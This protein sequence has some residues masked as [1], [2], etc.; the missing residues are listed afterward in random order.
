M[1]VYKN[2]SNKFKNNN[3]PK[4]EKIASADV[5]NKKTFKNSIVNAFIK[6]DKETIIDY[7]IKDVM[8]PM[9]KDALDTAISGAIH[10]LLYGENVSVF[11]NHNHYN[12]NSVNSRAANK[13]AYT[14]TYK[15]TQDFSDIVLK[16]RVDAIN[17]LDYLKERINEYDMCTIADFY[18][19]VGVSSGFMDSNYGWTNLD[20]A[21]VCQIRGGGYKIVFPKPRYL[22]W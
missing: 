10:M 3:K 13:A 17:V 4:V 15:K 20:S 16:N 11:K 2:N 6:E 18:E 7:V 12:Y 19:S 9:I 8:L 14:N 1:E 22:E 5:S 21:Y